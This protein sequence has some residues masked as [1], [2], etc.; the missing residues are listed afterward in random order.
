M[1]DAAGYHHRLPD[2]IGVQDLVAAETG[3]ALMRIADL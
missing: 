1:Y 3:L 2:R